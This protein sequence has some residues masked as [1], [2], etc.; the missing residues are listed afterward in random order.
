MEHITS[1]IEL[2]AD[3]HFKIEQANELVNPP[4]L[5][6]PSLSQNLYL[7]SY[8]IKVIAEAPKRI[9]TTGTTPEQGAPKYQTTS[10]SGDM[11]D[12]KVKNTVFAK[13][14]SDQ[15]EEENYN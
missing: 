11:E 13:Y 4:D 2:C 3:V 15:K 14:R 5:P 1:Q 10:T 12:F 9:N 8:I 6:N 7:P